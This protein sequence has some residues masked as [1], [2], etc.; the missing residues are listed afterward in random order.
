[1]HFSS[2]P[3]VSLLAQVKSVPEPPCASRPLHRPGQP[4]ARSTAKWICPESGCPGSPN[5]PSDPAYTPGRR[6]STIN[7]RPIRAK[8]IPSG[9]PA[10]WNRARDR[11]PYK[12][13]QTP[14]MVVLLCEGNT[15]SYRRFFLDGRPHNL[16]LDPDC[17]PAIPSRSGTA[18]RWWWT[19]S[20]STTRPGWMRPAS[21][22][23]MSCM[24]WNATGRPDL[25]HLISIF[26][27]RPEGFYQTLRVQTNLHAGAGLG[28]S[29]IRLPG[30]SRRHR[31]A[32]FPAVYR[33]PVPPNLI[34]VLAQPQADQTSAFPIASAAMARK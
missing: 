19:P 14:K 16:D 28:A 4:L 24:W 3:P 6:S 30:N 27:R 11:M 1:M 29:G 26:A 5:L 12:I 23:A 17:G 8:T 25:G 13:V 21:R 10:E 22:T 2:C 32:G 18:T 33:L 31:I 15:H 34:L 20:A 7:G 9:V